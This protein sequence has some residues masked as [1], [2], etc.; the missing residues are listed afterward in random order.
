MKIRES[1]L[2]IGVIAIGLVNILLSY[3]L[4]SIAQGDHGRDLYCFLKVL[5][6]QMP[7]RDF[8]WI[9]GPLMPYYY[10][11]WYKVLG[12]SI[13]SVKIGESLL[14]F[15]CILSVYVLSREVMAPIYSFLSS[16]YFAFSYTAVY[17]MVVDERVYTPVRHTYN[18]IGG[19]LAI[20]TILYLLVRFIR[21]EKTKYLL[22]AGLSTAVLMAIKLNIG[23]AFV[24]AFSIYL[25][26]M[27]RWKDFLLYFLLSILIALIIY[28]P[29][30][31]E[32]NSL[33]RSFPYASS[34]HQHFGSIFFF[35]F[36]PILERASFFRTWLNL[37]SYTPFLGLIFLCIS[38]IMSV[39][40]GSSLKIFLLFFLTTLFLSH[41]YILVSSLYSLNYF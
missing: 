26:L 10:A 15:L 22:G 14:I 30:I 3:D 16:L 40:K 28:L 34:Q 24:V 1:I 6:G 19:T 12:V 38:I 7:I 36:R 39:K 33:S 32:A 5:E 29:F 41:E 37:V 23:V 9:Y 27:K 4:Q 18:H 13:L 25:L 11:F 8:D 35:T 2:I 21:L 20:I 31:W 17:N